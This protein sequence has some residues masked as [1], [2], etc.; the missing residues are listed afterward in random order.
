[1]QIR[2]LSLLVPGVAAFL[3]FAVVGPV[4]AQE[5]EVVRSRGNYQPRV[6]EIHPDFTLPRIDSGEPVSLSSL[7]GKKVLLIHFASW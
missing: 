4:S 7:R 5:N 6:G 1:M 2:S 3:L